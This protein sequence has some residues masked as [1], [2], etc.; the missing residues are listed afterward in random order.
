MTP[1]RVLRL[2]AG[3]DQAS[4]GSIVMDGRGR[5]PGASRRA[6]RGHGVPA[7][8]GQSAQPHWWGSTKG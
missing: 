1:A 4:K 8:R 7:C 2:L 3:L 6:R 5:Y